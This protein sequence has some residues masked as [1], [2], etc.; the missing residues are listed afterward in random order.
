LQ[1]EIDSYIEDGII[2]NGN[3]DVE[4]TD[5]Q[6]VSK[7]TIEIPEPKALWRIKATMKQGEI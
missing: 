6:F 2:E 7:A 3:V 4:L 5:E 1:S